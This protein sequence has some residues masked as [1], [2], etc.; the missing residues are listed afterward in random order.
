MQRDAQ[1]RAVELDFPMHVAGEV[2]ELQRSSSITRHQ[3]EP[4]SLLHADDNGSIVIEQQHCTVGEPLDTRQCDGA[5][6]ATVG[7][8]AQTMT[9]RVDFAQRQVFD[10]VMMTDV[11]E[12][13]GDARVGGVPD[14]TVEQ[15]HRISAGRLD[16]D[17]RARTR[18]SDAQV[19]YKTRAPAAA[20]ARRGYA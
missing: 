9:L 11:M 15:E 12:R 19:G 7:R 1:Q 5:L 20:G 2:P 6:G 4:W 17:S 14:D 13:I 16:D 3:R 10:P 18:K 8:G